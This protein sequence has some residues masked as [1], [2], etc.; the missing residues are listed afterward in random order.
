MYGAARSVEM[1]TEHDFEEIT[2]GSVDLHAIDSAV[3][4]NPSFWRISTRKFLM[5]DPLSF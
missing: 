2:V 5:A 4:V 1:G 3:Y